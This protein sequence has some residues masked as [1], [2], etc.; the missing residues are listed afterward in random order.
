M[1][2]PLNLQRARGLCILLRALRRDKKLTQQAL[3]KRLGRPQSFIAKVEAGARA[4]DVP[5][6]LEYLEALG[7]DPAPFLQV[8]LATSMAPP[9]RHSSK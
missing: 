8:L 5:E 4:L 6:W 7:A 2:R 3:A 9:K 1:N